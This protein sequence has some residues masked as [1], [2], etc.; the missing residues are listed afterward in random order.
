M[1]EAV[2]HSIL[3][4]C[5]SLYYSSLFEGECHWVCGVSLC[6][7]FC[8][9]RH[10]CEYL[11]QWIIILVQSLCLLLQHQHW[12][13]I[14]INW[15]LAAALC[16]EDPEA[17]D[18]QNRPLLFQKL[19][20]GKDVGVGQLEAMNRGLVVT[21]LVVLPGKRQASSPMSISS[22]ALPCGGTEPGQC[23]N[24]ASG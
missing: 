4:V 3:L 6:T 24:M 22:L 17:M 9:T 11:L 8:P 2:S 19:I 16:R 1:S 5:E 7:P 20:E 13:F 12:T 14:E 18:L 10:T 23:T 21:E 15:Y